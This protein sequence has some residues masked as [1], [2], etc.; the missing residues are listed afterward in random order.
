VA[1]GAQLQLAFCR[2]NAG[3]S[4]RQHT[5]LTTRKGMLQTHTIQ[6]HSIGKAGQN[7]MKKRKIQ[8]SIQQYKSYTQV[9]SRLQP[10]LI[11]NTLLTHLK[12]HHE[13]LQKRGDSTTTSILNS[14]RYCRHVTSANKHNSRPLSQNGSSAQHTTQKDSHRNG[15]LMDYLSYNL[16]LFVELHYVL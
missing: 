11:D 5:S 7:H 15:S 10:N 4:T 3:F 8:F 12:I 6:V 9:I 13:S 14:W 16:L 2:T 1:L